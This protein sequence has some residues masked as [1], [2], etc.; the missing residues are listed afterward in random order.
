GHLVEIIRAIISAAD[1]AKVSLDDAARGNLQKIYSRWPLDNTYPPAMDLK[2]L[3]NERLPA[4]LTLFIEEHENGDKQFVIQ[5]CNG[6]IVGDRLT[7]NKV[8][9]DDYRFHDVFHVAFAVH[10]GWSPV[11]RALFHLKRK[12]KPEIDENQDG[13]RAILIEE[14]VAT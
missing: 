11:L 14:G 6:I 13:A 3:K 1:A 9:R 5:K 12:S 2:C 8:E 7:D 10:L 4:R